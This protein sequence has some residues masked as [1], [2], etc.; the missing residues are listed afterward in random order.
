MGRLTK[1]VNNKV[2]CTNESCQ[3]NCNVCYT[4]TTIMKKLAHYEDLEEHGRLIEL[5]CA[6]GE[7]VWDIDSMCGKRPVSHKIETLIYA[8]FVKNLF[9]HR[10][11]LTKEEAEAKLEELEG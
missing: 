6:V 11:F 7:E 9:G 5:P 10:F 4:H 3:G 1:V 2:Y 8:L